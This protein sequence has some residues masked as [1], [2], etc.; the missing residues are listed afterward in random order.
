MAVLL[1]IGCGGDFRSSTSRTDGGNGNSTGGKSGAGAPNGGNSGSTGDDSGAGGDG[2]GGA[3]SGGDSGGGAAGKSAG[4]A[5]NG[6]RA[7]HGN[8]GAQAGGSTSTGGSS[9]AGNGG[10]GGS[11]GVTGNGGT[12]G[13]GAGGKDTS[14][15]A[16]DYDQKCNFDSQCSLVNDTSDACGCK[17][18]L[19][20]AI[21]SGDIARWNAD[22]QA[23]NCSIPICP[24]LPCPEMLA[25]CANGTCAA[26][27]PFYVE[28]QN[29]DT[30]CTSNDQC[31]Q[32]PVGE[33]CAP[34]TCAFGA[35]SA[36]GQ[37]QYK[38]DRAKVAC[39]PALVG[40]SCAPPI[41][42]PMCSIQTGSSGVCVMGA[43][44]N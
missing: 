35:V 39:S 26:R 13:G 17:T 41:T 43:M 36:T 33:I 37:Q 10:T 42:S 4:G 22:R 9:G 6:G 21:S 14:Q 8:G 5:A 7:G 32:I 20:A 38:A 18:C 27:K 23:F 44:P 29:Y 19:N 15:H 24:G 31:T 25:A 11:G 40:C 16:D 12:A 30:A 28:A 2:A 34:C 3:S 1:L